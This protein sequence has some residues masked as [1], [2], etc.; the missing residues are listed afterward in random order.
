MFTYRKTDNES[1]RLVD[2]YLRDIR[3]SEPLSRKEEAELARRARNGDELARQKLITANLRFVVSVAWDYAG[4]GL[5][6]SELICEGN[7][8]LLEA[9]SRFDE[10]LR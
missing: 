2:A 1:A 9:V 8:G 10:R 7:V 3:D 4:R 6:M 5:S